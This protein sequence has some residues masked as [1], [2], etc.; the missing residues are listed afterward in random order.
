MHVGFDGE[1]YYPQ[2]TDEKVTAYDANNSR[3][4]ISG[5]H[6]TMSNQPLFFHN[7]LKDSRNAPD[8][9]SSNQ[10]DY[11]DIPEG[12]VITITA[13]NAV[14]NIIGVISQPFGNM[15][16]VQESNPG[17]DFVWNNYEDRE[18]YKIGR[19]A[20]YDD[21]SP[22]EPVAGITQSIKL[23]YVRNISVN[24]FLED[25]N[26]GFSDTT[27]RAMPVGENIWGWIPIATGSVNA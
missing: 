13:I 11:Q 22:Y 26:D 7:I 21:S 23:M 2:I 18:Y 9:T 6:S 17:Q 3:I 20:A 4:T 19:K 1:G 8:T 25:G 10:P 27:R 5:S 14:A 12:T 24:P 16:R 15:G